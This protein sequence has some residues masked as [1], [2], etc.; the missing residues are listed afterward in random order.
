MTDTRP[1]VVTL[2]TSL[3]PTPDTPP[4]DWPHDDG[5]PQTPTERALTTTATAA[6]LRA[7]ADT[8]TPDPG[9]VK[10]VADHY[11]I[12]VTVTTRTDREAS[13]WEEAFTPLDPAEILREYEKLAHLADAFGD[14]D[15]SSTSAPKAK[16]RPS[17]STRPPP[18]TF[19]PR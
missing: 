16:N 14:A 6:E 3:T 2:L 4:Q 13:G 19:G 10:H 1:D 15:M 12:E 7:A 17:A 18:R 11:G 5:R 9:H 8:T